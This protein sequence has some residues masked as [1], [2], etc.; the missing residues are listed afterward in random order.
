MP[1]SAAKIAS[2]ATGG[3]AKKGPS[4]ASFR[5]I[6]AELDD[7]EKKLERVR[8]LA[9]LAKENGGKAA[10]QMLCSGETVVTASA[11][12]FVSG[13][14]GKYRK[15]FRIGRALTALSLG[16]WGLA[17]TLTGKSSHHQMAVATGLVTAESVEA[18]YDFGKKLNTEKGWFAVDTGSS[19][20]GTVSGVVGEAPEVAVTPGAGGGGGRTR[21][22]MPASPGLEAFRAR[23][24]SM[25]A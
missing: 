5:K 4:A 17:R 11:S 18:S 15:Y 24:R 25:A 9:K 22:I 20:Q 14:S 10:T 6:Q 3:S 13:V 8:R 7:K 21:E 12:S 1:R 23:A 19:A 16:G 2:A